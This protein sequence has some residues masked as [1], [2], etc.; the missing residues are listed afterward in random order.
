MIRRL[1]ASVSVLGLVA[2]SFAGCGGGGGGGRDLT[3][4][5][6]NV[7]S[8]SGGSASLDGSRRGVWA[9]LAS[10]FFGSEAIAQVPGITVAIANTDRST[11]TDENGFFRMEVGQFGVVNLLFSGNGVNAGRTVVLP[12]GGSYQLIDV[13]IDGGDV[14][15]GD[16]QITFEGPITAV[17]C[18]QNLIV[19]TSGG[20]VNFR[21]RIGGAIL[22]DEQG[23][24]IACGELILGQGAEVFALVEQLETV[25][26]TEVQVNPDLVPTPTITPTPEP[27]PTVTATAAATATAAETVVTPT[28]TATPPATPTAT[29]G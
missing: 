29:S 12:F 22:R 6:G 4:V 25:I 1:A 11:V 8:A 21:V 2:L 13:D 16:E 19:V 10:L 15:V 28:A 26:A 9:R 20:R 17:D 27:S 18:N 7:R 3:I 14:T 23:E 5:S 24:E